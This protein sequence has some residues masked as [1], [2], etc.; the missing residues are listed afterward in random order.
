MQGR[1]ILLVED[2]YFI[3]ADMELAF[4]AA[5]A[6]VVGPV[7]SVEAALGL[8]R[9]GGALDGAVL[10]INLQ[11]EMAFPVADALME[12]GIPFIFATGYDKK[13]VPGRYAHVTRCEKPVDPDRVITALLG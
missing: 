8:I 10:D 12:R 13:V 7:A 4:A 11:D 9:A 5:G 2:E 6:E 3:A 1:R